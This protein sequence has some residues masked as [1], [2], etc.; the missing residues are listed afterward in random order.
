MKSKNE[1]ALP[2]TF[3]DFLGVSFSNYENLL[4]QSL[5]DPNQETCQLSLSNGIQGYSSEIINRILQSDLIF[6]NKT[7]LDD[8]TIK[9]NLLFEEDFNSTIDGFKTIIQGLEKLLNE[10]LNIENS[11]YDGL[12]FEIIALFLIGG[13]GSSFFLI[14]INLLRY[15][16]MNEEIQLT[17]EMLSLIPLA[18]LKDDGTIYMLKNL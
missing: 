7:T 14:I 10:N 17:K 18:N 3:S 15:K 2:N 9:N 4:R 12:Y 5:C 8:E 13:F 16:F 1:D 11:L 6:S